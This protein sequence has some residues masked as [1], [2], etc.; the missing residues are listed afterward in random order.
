MLDKKE[1][2]HTATLQLLEQQYQLSMDGKFEQILEQKERQYQAKFRRLETELL[3]AKQGSAHAPP[4]AASAEFQNALQAKEQ[5]YEKQLQ[6]MEDQFANELERL[7]QSAS[8]SSSPSSPGEASRL[9]TRLAEVEY[10]LLQKQAEHEAAL[11]DA[12]GSGG[13]G[14]GGGDHILTL[15]AQVASLQDQLS[16]KDAEMQSTIQEALRTKRLDLQV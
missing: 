12:V 11:R 13:G 14:G 6:S 15:E 5:E 8:S 10:D 1:E 9:R 16:K 7:K 3:D 4:A 2:E